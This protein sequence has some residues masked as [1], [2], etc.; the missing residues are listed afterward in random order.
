M[1][2]RITALGGVVGALWGTPGICCFP[3]HF[4]PEVQTCAYTRGYSDW[5]ANPSAALEG[6][7]NDRE[8]ALRIIKTLV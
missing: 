1:H 5:M 3:E 4:W 7:E 2:A 8:L 6:N